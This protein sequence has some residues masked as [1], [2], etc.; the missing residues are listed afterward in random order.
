[1]DRSLRVLVIDDDPVMRELLE[2]LLQIAG[3]TPEIYESGETALLRLG[4]H[5][6]PAFDVV[7]TDLHMPGIQ[8]HELASAL[9]AERF[10]QTVL[11]G[12]SG[13][14]PSDDETR[15]LDELLQKPFT[16]AQF[17]QAVAKARDRRYTTTPTGSARAPDA[18]PVLDEE[19][20]GQLAALLPAAQLQGLYD[21][22]VSD[23]QSRVER[24]R[25]SLDAGDIGSV[26]SEAH[27]IKGGTGMV[28]ARELAGMA[29]ALEAG[30]AHDAEALDDFARASDRLRRMLNERLPVQS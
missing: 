15:L 20:F 8:G 6:G 16:M 19:I 14:F 4:D 30:T 11:V 26:R 13:S 27:A 10:P 23:I 12:M 1:M 21:L 3:H 5:S 9:L 2:A 25:A 22:T 29:A 18:A 24:M 28:G 7:L 17:E